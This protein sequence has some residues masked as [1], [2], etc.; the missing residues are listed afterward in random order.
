MI[1]PEGT[2]S[3]TGRIDTENFSYGAGRLIEHIPECQVLCIYLRGDKQNTYSSIP[4]FN[5]RL[6]I[7]EG[8]A[9]NIVNV[10]NIPSE[11]K[12]ISSKC[13]CLHSRHRPCLG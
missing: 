9:F 7:P 12:S 10:T 2:R 6:S 1:F 11:G 8:G 3:R 13:E 4:K 5:D